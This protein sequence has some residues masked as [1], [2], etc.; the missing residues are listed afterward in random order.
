MLHLCRTKNKLP[1]LA[2]NRHPVRKGREIASDKS[3]FLY[4][5]NANFAFITINKWLVQLQQTTALNAT[6]ADAAHAVQS[7]S[8]NP[9]RIYNALISTLVTTCF[10]EK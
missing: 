8:T 3:A 1:I 6:T 5:L 2:V 9:Q 7:A 4:A 10:R